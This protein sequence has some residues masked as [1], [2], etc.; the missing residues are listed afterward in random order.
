VVDLRTVV[1]IEDVDDAAV[2]VDPVGDAIGTAPGPVAASERAE[3]WLA[4]PVRVDR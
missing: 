1:D 4:N 2:L 3:E